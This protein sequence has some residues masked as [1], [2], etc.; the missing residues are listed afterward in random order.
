MNKLWRKLSAL[1]LAAAVTATSLIF[2]AAYD[3]SMQIG[4]DSAGDTAYTLNS[5]ASLTAGRDGQ[6]V[7]LNGTPNSYVTVNGDLSGVSS[8]YSISV[9]IK[10]NDT[11]MWTRVYD[12]G[13]GEDKYVFLAPSS[14]F[15]DGL[16]RF[17]VKNGGAE[18]VLMSDTR[19]NVGEWNNIVVTYDGTTTVMYLNGFNVG[20]TTDITIKPSDIGPTTNNWLGRSQYA[21]D[22]YFNGMIDGFAVYDSAL[23]EEEVREVAAEA[24]TDAVMEYAAKDDKYIISVDF[25]NS[26]DEKIFYADPGQTVKA[27]VNIKNHTTGA[28]ALSASVTAGESKQ[29][30]IEAAG[31]TTL[32]LEATAANA[33]LEVAVTDTATGQVFQTAT[34]P[35]GSAVVFPENVPL[36]EDDTVYPEGTL[37][38]ETYGAH[39]PTIFKDPAGGKYW[40]YSSHNLVFESEDLIN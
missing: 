9:W 22:P 7:S 38:T 11:A 1:T 13:T 31:E 16:P 27:E 2:P 40:A 34:L 18:Q 30:S 23:S 15:G 24:Y 25:Y 21:A 26:D 12:F 14:S 37:T 29:A 4:F 5:A 39:D 8:P 17:V 10:P 35:V 32:Y 6:A 36:D 33:D 20:Q 19:L 3:A 28:A